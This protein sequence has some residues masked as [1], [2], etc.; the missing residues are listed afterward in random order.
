MSQETIT[1][2]VSSEEPVPVTP[3]SYYA[4]QRASWKLKINEMADA[5]RDIMNLANVQ[6]DLYSNR[7]LAIDQMH[8]LMNLHLK[9]SEKHKIARA[10]SRKKYEM[11]D[12]K[13]KDINEQVD[14][15]T[16]GLK[17]SLDQISN[18]IE[19]FKEMVKNVDAMLYGIKYRLEFENS[20]RRAT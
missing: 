9:I 16:A 15:H 14:A 11:G 12:L 4:Q 17:T 18:Q 1:Q 13:V 2:P 5:Q 3:E 19:F 7:H 10:E 6:I 20:Y 8:S